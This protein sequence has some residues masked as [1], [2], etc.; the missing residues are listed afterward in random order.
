MKQITTALISAFAAIFL[1]C[2]GILAGPAD[3]TENET[4]EEYYIIETRHQLYPDFQQID[5]VSM[6]EPFYIGEDEWEGKVIGFN[7]HLGITMEGEALQMSDT[8]YN[9]A[10]RIQ[11]S[12]NGEVKQESWGFFVMKAPHFKREDLLGFRLVDFRVSEKYKKAP[13]GK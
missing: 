4:E 1:L 9:P 12:Y 8:L 2:P 13:A 11:V 3:S 6:E 7:P 5:T 10:V